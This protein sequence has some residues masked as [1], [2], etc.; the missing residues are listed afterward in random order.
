[1]GRKPC[2]TRRVSWTRLQHH[3]TSLFVTCPD[4]LHSG[5]TNVDTL[6]FHFQY[7][8]LVFGRPVSQPVEAVLCALAYN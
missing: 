4:T 5:G 7:S 1:M 8:D 3:N 6:H 2:G